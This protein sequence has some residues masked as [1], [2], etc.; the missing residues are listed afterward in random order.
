MT[1]IQEEKDSPDRK[2]NTVSST[3][4]FNVQDSSSPLKKLIKPP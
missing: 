4:K 3:K 1:S 2:L